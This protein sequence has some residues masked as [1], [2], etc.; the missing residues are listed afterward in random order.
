MPLGLLARCRPDSV[1]EFRLAAPQRFQDGLAL[2][3]AGRRTAAIY[4]WGYAAEMTLKAAYFGLVGFA[5]AREIFI[6]DLRSSAANAPALGFT[7]GGSLHHVESWAR[8]LVST[9]ANT[10][11]RA[12]A[13]AAFGSAIVYHSQQIQQRWNEV[14]RYHKNVAYGYEVS[15]VRNATHWLL[16]NSSRL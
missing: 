13:N 14:L 2:A 6:R 3:A 8:L 12:Y 1:A 10:S 11:G 4:L 15:S 7:W 9:R 16:L 5:P